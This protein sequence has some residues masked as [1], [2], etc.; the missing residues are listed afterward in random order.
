MM[1]FAMPWSLQIVNM[2]SLPYKSTID[3]LKT[4]PMWA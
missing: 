2:M 1:I 3:E 4:Y